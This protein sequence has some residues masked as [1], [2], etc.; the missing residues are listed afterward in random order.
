VIERIPV[1]LEGER[2]D[3]VVSLVT[4]LSR[5]EA[6]VVVAEGLVTLDGV[7]VTSGKVRVR[8]EQEI[9]IEGDH[10]PRSP[11]VPQA[12]PAVEL[13]VVHADDDVIVLDKAEGLVVH[14]GAGIEHGTVVHGLLARFPEVAGVG[15]PHRP[16][17]VHRLDR[18]TSGLLVVARS[19]RA[20]R[21]LVAQLAARQAGRRYLAI[22]CGA[23]EAVT[24]L[25]DAPLGRSDRDRTRMAVRSEGRSART[26]FD[27]LERFTHPLPAALLSC[28]LET[29]RTH[30][31]RVHL[32]AVG[33]PVLGD[34][35][36]GG[37]REPLPVERPMLHATELSFE[38]PGSG[39]R[40]TFRA[41]PPP[42]FVATVDQLRTASRRALD[43]DGSDDPR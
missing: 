9:A 1:A 11:E 16:G 14:P 39:E 29:G 21:S 41:D 22:T 18:G 20:Y 13:T 30:Q 27:V 6:T 32:S 40:V 31:I 10:Q 3:R 12:E 37:N 25:I 7:V 2:V 35:R 26:R 15:D 28:A 42:D 4:G 8:A 23:P 5:S 36:Y 34:A 38:H 24:G 43:E 33:H 19:D 17:I